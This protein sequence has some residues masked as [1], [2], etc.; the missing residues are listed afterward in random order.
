MQPAMAKAARIRPSTKQ[1]LHFPLVKSLL[2]SN[3]EAKMRLANA[4]VAGAKLTKAG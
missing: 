3:R 4:A 1:K 2:Y